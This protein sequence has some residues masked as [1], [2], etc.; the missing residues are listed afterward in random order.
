[1]SKHE[2]KLGAFRKISTGSLIAL[3]SV[4]PAFA[5]NWITDWAE[6]W[7]PPTGPVGYLFYGAAGLLVVGVALKVFEAYVASTEAKREQRPS[8]ATIEEPA[9][10]YSI[11]DHRNSILNP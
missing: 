10:A 2:S 4:T 8:D 7:S 9:R 3:G 11:G 5:A 1:M 6:T